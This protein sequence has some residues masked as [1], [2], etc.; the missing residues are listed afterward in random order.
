M[1]G[2]QLP[3]TLSVVGSTVM[4]R[5]GR[6]CDSPGP[7]GFHVSVAAEGVEALAARQQRRGPSLIRGQPVRASPQ[8]PQHSQQ[9]VTL[10]TSGKSD[11]GAFIAMELLSGDSP[12]RRGPQARSAAARRCR[13]RWRSDRRA[14]AVDGA[15]R[16]HHPSVA[17]SQSAVHLPRERVARSCLDFW[18]RQGVPLP[19]DSDM[20]SAY[21]RHRR[22]QRAGTALPVAGTAAWQSRGPPI[23]L[24]GTSGP[25]CRRQ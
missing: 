17:T 1:I 5:H 8:P 22:R 14:R 13:W 9:S 4:R 2:R 24:V 6:T 10:L 3:R 7:C 12:L 21:H 15:P 18:T 11:E 16:R 19:E 23:E 25:C 20:P